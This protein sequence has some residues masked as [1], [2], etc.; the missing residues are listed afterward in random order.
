M[1]LYKT[2][3][4][5]VVHDCMCWCLDEIFFLSIITLL[6]TRY[7]L[8]GK[9][10]T[11]PQMS[12]LAT[13]LHAPMQPNDFPAPVVSKHSSGDSFTRCEAVM[14]FGSLDLHHGPYA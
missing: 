1:A 11:F 14:I 2:V 12:S 13:K 7:S 8:G 6:M 9:N 10:F 5:N 3:I 4:T